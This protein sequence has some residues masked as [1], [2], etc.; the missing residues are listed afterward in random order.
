V[1]NVSL[2]KGIIIEEDSFAIKIG[3]M[4]ERCLGRIRFENLKEVEVL[5]K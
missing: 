2:K 4:E 3:R 5:R 1:K